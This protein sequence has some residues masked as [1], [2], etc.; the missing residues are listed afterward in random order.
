MSY[1]VN[2]AVLPKLI[3]VFITITIK[4]SGVFLGETDKVIIKFIW[5]CKIPLKAKKQS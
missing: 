1:I 2:R 3:Y 5:K 4:I